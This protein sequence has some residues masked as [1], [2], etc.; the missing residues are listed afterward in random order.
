MTVATS[1][2]LQLTADEE[3][4]ERGTGLLLCAAGLAVAYAGM[5]QLW[6]LEGQSNLDGSPV[7]GFA[8]AILA[9][10]GTVVVALARPHL[11]QTAAGATGGIG[12]FFVTW[13][14][15]ALGVPSHTE[16]ATFARLWWPFLLIGLVVVALSAVDLARRRVFSAPVTWVRPPGRQKVLLVAGSVLMFASL[17]LPISGLVGWE[18]AHGRF[19]AVPVVAVALALLAATADLRL[20]GAVAGGARL[21]AVGA[22]AYLAP[23]TLAAGY[24]AGSAASPFGLALAVGAVCL[25]VPAVTRVR[26]LP[27][28]GAA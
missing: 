16:D 18:W 7:D 5:N 1:L 27:A 12:L 15:A 4:L 24:L 10:A 19:L 9:L 21:P 28:T 3:E 2:L 20:A 17:A 8:V 26:P 23:T 13:G 25:G 14:Y 6:W 11:A 22:L